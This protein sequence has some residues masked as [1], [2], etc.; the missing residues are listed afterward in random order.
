MSFTVLLSASVP[1]KARSK[2]Y[3]KIPNAQI[4]IEEA[5]ISLT[6]NVFE[7]GGTIVF[8]GH[9]SISRLIAMVALEFDH[10]SMSKYLENPQIIIYQSKAYYEVM[11][12]DTAQ[13]YSSGRAQ[14]RWTEAVNNEK[15][16]PKIKGEPQ[17]T[18]SLELMRKEMILTD[19]LDGMVCIGGME[20]VEEEF[21]LFEDKNEKNGWGHPI[22]VFSSTGG[23]ALK[24]TQENRR[25]ENIFSEK[26]LMP[27]DLEVEIPMDEDANLELLPYAYM[28]AEII[29]KLKH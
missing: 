16:N 14:I 15:F 26:Q 9:P 17:C 24:I 13:L 28:T 4:K 3:Q 11:P 27:S 23:A 21:K 5:V 10:G 8:G 19:N 18:K 20:G 1:S 6:R 25:L 29:E 7:A 12:A 22:F 2:D